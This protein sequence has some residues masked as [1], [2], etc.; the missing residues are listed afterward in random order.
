MKLVA[1]EERHRHKENLA[2]CIYKFVS[3]CRQ[4]IAR[5]KRTF[6]KKLKTFQRNSRGRQK[7]VHEKTQ[8]AMYLGQP[9]LAS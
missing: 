1:V 4:Y 5:V 6:A 3:G 7:W 9:R 2:E 8:Q